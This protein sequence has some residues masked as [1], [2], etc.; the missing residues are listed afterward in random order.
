MYSIRRQETMMLW[1]FDCCEQEVTR[2]H[3]ILG[4][5]ILPCKRPSRVCSFLR[6]LEPRDTHDNVSSYT[7]AKIHQASP[8][9]Y[10]TTRH[11]FVRFDDTNSAIIRLKTESF[12]SVAAMRADCHVFLNLTPFNKSISYLYLFRDST[13]LL[14]LDTLGEFHLR[15]QRPWLTLQKL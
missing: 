2:T 10:A 9:R 11:G 14:L 6:L 3:C 13:L 15:P 12:L 4:R 1:T 7:R 8:H 5:M